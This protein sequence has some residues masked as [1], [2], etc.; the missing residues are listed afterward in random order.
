MK[1]GFF[2]YRNN[3]YY[4]FYNKEQVSGGEIISTTKLEHIK[5][6]YA[7]D[8][9]DWEVCFYDNL[10]LLEPEYEDLQVMLM[11]IK[12]FMNL[13]TEQVVDFSL[14]EERLNVSLPKELKLVVTGER[15]DMAHTFVACAIYR[16]VIV[17]GGIDKVENFKRDSFTVQDSIHNLFLEYPE[18]LYGFTSI[19]YSS[20]ANA[21]KSALVF[22]VPYGEQLTIKTYTE[23][24]FEKGVQ[25]AKK[26]LEIILSQVEEILNKCEIKYY[27]PLVTQNN[28]EDLL[29]SFSFKYAA[30]NARLGWIGKND[31]VV[32][33][34]YGPR[35]RLSAIVIDEQ[36][37]YDERILKSNCP[38]SCKKCVDICPY[39]ALYNMNW[40]IDSLRN[41]I[42][43]Y[44][45]CNQKRGLYIEKH[46]RMNACGL[47][48][49]VCPFG[50]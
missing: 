3:I 47:C 6:N 8:G 26:V 30:V 12:P 22:A 18:V 41:D 45:L 34:K 36:F 14:I 4:G 28:E 32:T 27:I 37:V 10:G 31:V 9:E 17:V 38:D 21:Y 48:M 29:A 46:G 42:I 13:N 11:T 2:V 33:D 7:I 15:K 39:K 20:Y 16:L 49:V 44:K 23:E 40:N 50:T 35:V 19:S 43:D 24:K 25:D 5:T 1:E